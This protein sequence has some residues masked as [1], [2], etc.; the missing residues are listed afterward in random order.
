LPPG[1]SMRNEAC[2]SHVS[3]PAK[4][5]SLLVGAFRRRD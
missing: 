4:F 3:V 5:V 2:P 1:V